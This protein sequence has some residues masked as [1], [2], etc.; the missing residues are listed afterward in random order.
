MLRCLRSEILGEVDELLGLVL[1]L[2]LLLLQSI[3][4]SVHL[5]LSVDDI[6]KQYARAIPPD[7]LP[8][9][10]HYSGE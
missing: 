5:N 3:F 7:G 10:N 9:R 1:L 2:L 4:Y 8:A 6:R